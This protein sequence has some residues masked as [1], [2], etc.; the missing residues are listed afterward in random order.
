MAVPTFNP[1]MDRTRDLVSGTVWLFDAPPSSRQFSDLSE[2]RSKS[3]RV[4]A[5]SD[6]AR[7]RRTA[8]AALFAAIQARVIRERFC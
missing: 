2:N 6:C 8:F 5:I 3:A 1:T 4:R 7:T